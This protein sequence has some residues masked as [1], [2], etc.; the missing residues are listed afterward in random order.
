MS[1]PGPTPSLSP[2]T[3]TRSKRSEANREA[4]CGRACDELRRGATLRLLVAATMLLAAPFGASAETVNCNRVIYNDDLSNLSLGRITAGPRVHFVLN[5]VDRKGCPSAAPG[6]RSAK[7][8][9][10]GDPVVFSGGV[11]N[12]E[13]ICASAVDRQG[14]ETNGWLPAARIMPAAG[15][16]SWIGRWRRN[17]SARIDI[18]RASRGK[19]AVTGS[20]TW[21]SGAATH[22]GG[23]SATIDTESETRTFA[24]SADGQIAFGKAGPYD[25]AVRLKQLG[26]YLFAAD[27]KSC[28]G[29]NVSF[30]GLY[31]RR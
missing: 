31:R 2:E 26:P 23:I 6:C 28:G 20:A 24:S 16:P 11:A 12:G 1:S 18:T 9:M 7:S 27:N 22:D 30:T 14:E 17:T 29:A 10:L 8:L 4:L 5:A 13:F 19:A 25:C 21:G 3:R 15:A